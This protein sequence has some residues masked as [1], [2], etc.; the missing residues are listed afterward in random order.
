MT[1]VMVVTSCSDRVVGG[2]HWTRTSDLLHVKHFRLSAVLGAW[3]A[4]QNRLSYTVTGT[5]VSGGVGGDSGLSHHPWALRIVRRE[6]WI[7][8]A[9]ARSA[10]ADVVVPSAVHWVITASRRIHS[11]L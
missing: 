8:A 6:E 3:D 2:R 7:A 10:F 5:R 9:M 1:A 4:E 11:G